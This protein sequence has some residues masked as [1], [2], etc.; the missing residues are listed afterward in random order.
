MRYPD[1]I[2]AASGPMKNKT[3]ET[4]IG[5][6]R[7]SVQLFVLSE[8]EIQSGSDHAKVVFRAVHDIPTEVARP[9]DIWCDPHFHA[10]AGLAH[11]ARFGLMR[12]LLARG[13]RFQI[14]AVSAENTTAATPHV[15]REPRAADRVAQRHCPQ[16]RANDMMIAL[17]AKLCDG[18]PSRGKIVARAVGREPKSFDANAEIFHEEIFEIDATAPGVIA[19]EEL[20][21]AAAPA[22]LKGVEQAVAMVLRAGEDVCAPETDI[23][24]R[25]TIPVANFSL[26]GR[27][28]F[29]S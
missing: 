9:A 19:A 16:D 21:I 7:L 26:P 20:I 3:P 12:N 2:P 18:G 13:S 25:V 8:G 17:F 23:P 24:F 1:G 14:V 5:L 27:L 22:G 11:G 29:F 28:N 4:E 6:R 15:W 10:A